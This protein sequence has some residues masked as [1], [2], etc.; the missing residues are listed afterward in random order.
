MLSI[1][2]IGPYPVDEKV[3]RGGVESSVFGLACELA[4]TNKV[5][6]LD[7][8][9][10]ELADGIEQRE[11]LRI[12][13]FHNTGSHV[14]DAYKRISDYVK[15][16]LDSKPDICHIHG[17]SMFNWKL[18]KRLRKYEIPVIVTVHGLARVEKRQ[19]LERHFSPKTLY[20]LVVQ[21]YAERRL[22]QSVPKIIV[23]TEYVEKAIRD[24][25]LAHT[26]EIFIIP[27]GINN[28]YFN[29]KCSES[30]RKILSVGAFSRRKGQLLLIKAFE[31]VASQVPDASLILCGTVAE[32]KYFK[33]VV[34]YIAG[35]AFKER[36][37]LK[38][39]VSQDELDS[40]YH[41][42]QI[43][44]LYSSEESQGIALL[45][46]MAAGLPVV[47]TRVGGIP[48]VVV[49]KK[50]G[51]LTAYNDSYSF[52]QAILNLL[53]DSLIWNEMSQQSRLV[54]ENY[55]WHNIAQ[56]AQKAYFN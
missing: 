18:F 47:A 46:A 41:Q 48:N 12:C 29:I 30:S 2:Q 37:V 22:L 53:T 19:N 10:F 4:K 45:E 36:I 32:E 6:V 23:D 26:P 38:T 25:S 56:S 49:D 51:I 39:D 13:R 21:S 35:S 28:R 20:Q 34:E 31:K 9:R 7:I 16:I 33:E 27:Q 14:K 5:T 50:T 42:A 3:I 8:P 54:A 40:L 24:Y 11:T 52:S 55:S 1:V 15:F 43:F 17:T 44:A